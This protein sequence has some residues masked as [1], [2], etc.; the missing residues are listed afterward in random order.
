M[1]LG[2]SLN[3]KKIKTSSQSRIKSSLIFSQSGG[4]NQTQY[5]LEEW[6]KIITWLTL[7]SGPHYKWLFQNV[8][9]SILHDTCSSM[10]GIRSFITFITPSESLIKKHFS[11]NNLQIYWWREIWGQTSKAKV[12][13]EGS[14][15]KSFSWFLWTRQFA[16]RK[17]KPEKEGINSRREI[18][19][20]Y[21]VQ[22]K[23]N[24]KILFNSAQER[25]IIIS[26]GLFTRRAHI[27]YELN[28]LLEFFP[29]SSIIRS[30]L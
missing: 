17:M 26:D 8:I 21:L 12:L 11:W 25:L 6:I 7:K 27:F 19:K 23:H 10:Q 4:K 30:V 24:E 3:K 28:L 16:F 1:S 29:Q 2:G 14:A 5:P 20:N 18:N 22:K 13:F 15:S 9:V